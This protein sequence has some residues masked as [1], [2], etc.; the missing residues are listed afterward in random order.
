MLSFELEG[1]MDAGRNFQEAL[2]VALVGVSLGGVHTLVVHAASATHTQLSREER[3]A[4]GVTDGLVRVSVG[5]EDPE[6]LLDDFERALG[7]A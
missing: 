4:R 3:I 1:G 6:D 5:I 2:E 7:K